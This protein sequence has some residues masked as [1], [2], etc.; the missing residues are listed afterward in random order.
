MID[1]PDS[2]HVGVGC[3][4]DPSAAASR[5]FAATDGHNNPTAQTNSHHVGDGPVVYDNADGTV[6]TRLRI[7]K[8]MHCD[9]VGKV[10][11]LHAGAD[12]YANIPVCV[13]P[14]QYTATRPKRSR[15][16]RRPATLVTA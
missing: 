5:W 16:Q 12:H 1:I 8:I 9:L 15:R 6:E 2:H 4:P 14:T 13:D 7:D 3:T 10:S 11:T